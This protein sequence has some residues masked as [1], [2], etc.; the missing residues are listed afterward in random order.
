MGEDRPYSEIERKRHDRQQR[1]PEFRAWLAAEADDLAQFVT[2]VPGLADLDDPWTPAG[3]A[4]IEDA[5][6]ARFPDPGETVTDEE[7][8]YLDLAARA[9]GHTYLRAVGAGKWVWLR[10]LTGNPIGAALE[11]PG[12]GV[13]IDPAES[14]R[15]VIFGREPD[16]L[17]R[18]LDALVNWDTPVYQ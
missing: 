11:F 3:L 6:L 1:S 7:M 8:V 10:I 14:I 4:A 5:A 17:V 13:Y 2:L 15:R 18:Q 16:T 12:I 9:I